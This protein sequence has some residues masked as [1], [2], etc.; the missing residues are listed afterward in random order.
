M[1]QK[2]EQ[3]S[4][5]GGAGNLV[6]NFTELAALLALAAPGKVSRAATYE[7]RPDQRGVEDLRRGRVKGRGVIGS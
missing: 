4:E 7:A 6:G 3:L 5:I 1:T 2:T